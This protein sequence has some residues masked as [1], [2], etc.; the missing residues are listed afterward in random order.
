MGD[1]D[2]DGYDDLFVTYWGQNVLYRNN[3]DGAFTD[4]TAKAGLLSLSGLGRTQM[5]PDRSCKTSAAARRTANPVQ[6][7]LH[8]F[9]TTQFQAVSCVASRSG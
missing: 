5:S 2:N 9:K 6:A 7:A 3:G 1:F 4:V 8:S